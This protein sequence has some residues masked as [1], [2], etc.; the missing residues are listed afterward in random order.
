MSWARIDDHANEHRKQLRA[1]AEACWLWTCG[2]MY[3]NRQA[4]RDGEIPEEVLGLL[5]PAGSFKTK[6]AKLADKLVE[7]GL[8]ERIQGG[9]RV[10]NWDKWNRS[11]EAVEAER[12]KGRERARRSFERRKQEAGPQ[13]SG[14][15]TAKTPEVFDR[16]DGEDTADSSPVLQPVFGVSSGST[17]L[18]ST[19]SQNNNPQS[20]HSDAPP[21]A[22]VVGVDDRPHKL[23]AAF[24]V[25][26]DDWGVISALPI[27]DGCQRV[28]V[29]WYVN[30]HLDGDSRTPTEWR[31]SFRH[32]ATRAWNER[33]S[34]CLAESRAASEPVA[35]PASASTLDADEAIRRMEAV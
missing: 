35:E 23:T 11:S 13:S 21:P 5:Y 28:L 10:H 1:G 32:W 16:R 30:H 8:W 26:A 3:C 14:E 25:P 29:R 31:R 2:L 4:A 24:A 7:V 22:V 17:P 34:E 15:D 9:Y 19:P 27:P 6:P 12:A 20:P 33:R 18:H